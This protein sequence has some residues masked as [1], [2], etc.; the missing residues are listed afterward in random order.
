MTAEQALHGERRLVVTL[1][2]GVV[3]A[4]HVEAADGEQVEHLLVDLL[5]AVHSADNHLLGVG[6]ERREVEVEVHLRRLGRSAD[7]HQAVDARVVG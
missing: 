5:L 7:V 6:I 1:L 4:L 2:T 3:G